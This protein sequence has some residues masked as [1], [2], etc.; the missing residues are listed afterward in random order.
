MICISCIVY[1]FLTVF[2]VKLCIFTKSVQEKHDLRKSFPPFSKCFGRNLSIFWDCAGV[3]LLWY[4]NIR[5]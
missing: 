2:N 5:G 4:L 3:I 1:K